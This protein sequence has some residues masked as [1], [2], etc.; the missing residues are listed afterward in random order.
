MDPNESMLDEGRKKANNSSRSNIEWRIGSDRDVSDR[1]GTFQL[2]TMGRSFHWMDQK[3]TLESLLKIIRPGGGV[4]IFGNREWFTRGTKN[5]QR[6]VY[7][8]TTDYLSNL[9][10]RTGPVEYD[11]PWHKKIAKFGF[12]DVEEL[13][14]YLNREWTVD[15][16]VGYLFSLSYCSPEKVGDQREELEK[17][18]RNRLANLDQD[19]FVQEDIVTIISGCRPTDN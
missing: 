13:S 1:L 4:A 15:E 14:I 10:D 18:V 6:E 11:D 17:S 7:S 5:W 16:I 2:V 3:Q 9:P 12:R 19:S 8:V